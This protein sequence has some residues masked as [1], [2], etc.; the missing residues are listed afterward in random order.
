M[1]LLELDSTDDDPVMKSRVGGVSSAAPVRPSLNTVATMKSGSLTSPSTL[2]PTTTNTDT[3]LVR[4]STP[5]TPLDNDK[6][7]YPFR[8]KHL[9]TETYTLYANRAEDRR[10][11]CDKIIE[12][13]TKHAAALFRQNAE[14]FTL[15]VLADAAFAYDTWSGHQRTVLIKGTSLSR[16]LDDVERQYANVTKPVPICRA[17]VN[18]AASFTQADGKVKTVVGTDYGIYLCNSGG[19][20][21]WIR[22]LTSPRVTQLA[23]LEDF[24]LLILIS[25][26]ALIAYHLDS[27]LP[28]SGSTG[29]T[30]KPPQ[31]LSG[32]RDVAFFSVGR[33]KDRYLIFYKKRE[34]LTSVFK[35]LEPVLH[36]S[37]AV[38]RNL[39]NNFGDASGTK[40]VIHT[41]TFRDY[42]D[43]T[44]QSDS[45]ALSLFTST[46]GVATS[47]GFDVLNLDKKAPWAIPDLSASHTIAIAK[48]LEGLTPL[49]M[50][51]L[52]SEDA[53]VAGARSST[54]YTNGYSS[55]M[56]NTTTSNDSAEY[57]LV[58]DECAIYITR[59]GE[60][61]RGV[62]M[63]FV[64]KAR[65]AALVEGFLV[66][67]D[68]D[69]VEVR[70]AQT[71]R[72]KQIISGRDV[73]AIDDG[74]AGGG[75]G[76]TIKV[77]MQHPEMERYQIVLEMVLNRGM[78]R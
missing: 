43:F 77:A 28:A 22:V 25:D 1:R 10:L 64:G 8:V 30:K 13:K 9:G 38:R 78:L 72:L 69:F 51:R 75:G 2:T 56:H 27:I 34:G 47:R 76:G 71:G 65:S 57:I 23:V 24:N 7:L 59:F 18:C 21:D 53:T 60:I 44:I 70:D 50:F 35:V 67:F 41:D 16:A 6:T 12:A 20:R 14:P 4:V 49:G 11:W 39:T 62:H 3:S 31:K 5:T 36:R 45:T 26:K 19:V 17:K 54:S 73:R 66:L 32:S 15:R 29:L 74:H 68:S 58:Y 46:I 40:T 48:R 42:D 63:E 33:M 55:S 61:S 37:T 52:P